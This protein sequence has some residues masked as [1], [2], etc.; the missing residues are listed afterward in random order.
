MYSMHCTTKTCVNEISKQDLKELGVH[1]HVFVAV[2][3]FVVTMCVCACIHG[4][5][6]K[7]HVFAMNWRV[8]KIV[9]H[10]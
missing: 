9:Q 1:V 8:K 2:H 6:R 3:V 5:S 7:L 10:T 4:N